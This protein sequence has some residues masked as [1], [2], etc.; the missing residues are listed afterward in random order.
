MRAFA[1][2]WKKSARAA[3]YEYAPAASLN[4]DAIRAQRATKKGLKKTTSKFEY[5]AKTAT[6]LPVKALIYSESM[7]NM[8][9]P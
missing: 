9:E 5:A 4:A 8:F 6:S 2:G 3:S 7:K 1:F